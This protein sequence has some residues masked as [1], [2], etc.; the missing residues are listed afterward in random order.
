[1]DEQ[2][3]S[4]FVRVD[5]TQNAVL[6]R[7]GDKINGKTVK[8]VEFAEPVFYSDESHPDLATKIII[9]DGYLGEKEIKIEH[10]SLRR[11]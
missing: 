6:V 3:R 11:R 4:G 2:A 10:T 9:E 7:V 5:E 1:M 8:R